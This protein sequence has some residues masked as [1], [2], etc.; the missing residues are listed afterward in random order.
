MINKDIFKTFFEKNYDYYILLGLIVLSFTITLIYHYEVL[1][2][3]TEGFY[4]QL[5]CFIAEQDEFIEHASLEI[6]D[7]LPNIAKYF[8]EI[9]IGYGVL[10]EK[11]IEAILG[12]SFIFGIYMLGKTIFMKTSKKWLRIILIM[13][14]FIYL[15]VII[16]AA[17]ITPIAGCL[18][19]IG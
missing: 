15:A 6:N 4:Y 8:D 14:S 9:I 18:I 2:T 11:I 7:L 1:D 13:L 16:N 19:H 12:I 3:N 5:P 17:I 10:I